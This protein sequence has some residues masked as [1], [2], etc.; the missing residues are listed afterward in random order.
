VDTAT[1]IQNPGIQFRTCM[2]PN[3]TVTVGH[4]YL[5]SAN[6]NEVTV[7]GVEVEGRW[8][9]NDQWSMRLAGAYSEGEKQNGDPLPSILPANGVLGLRY[10]SRT[11]RWALTGNLT[12]AAAKKMSD[13]RLSET[14]PGD[15][16]SSPEPD[17][18]SDAY[19]L[20]DLM[21]QVDI[22]KDLRL[23]AGIYN[24]LDERYYQW[25]RVRFVSEGTT[26]LY[27]YVTGEGIGRYSEPGRNFRL[28]LSWQF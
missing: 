7:K 12:H 20:V 24:V 14:S 4:E 21:S 28:S 1:F 13:A 11:Q 25:P 17:F 8:L 10:Q 27:G 5:M 2:G 9:F 19:T 18:L 26:T 23:T 6:V 22:T 16:F 3:C 15:F